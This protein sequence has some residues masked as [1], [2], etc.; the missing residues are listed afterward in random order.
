[1]PQKK[2]TEMSQQKKPAPDLHK[3]NN[4]FLATFA[5]L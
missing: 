1:M 5:I 4:A 3:G 2:M